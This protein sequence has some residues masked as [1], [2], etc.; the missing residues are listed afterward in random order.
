[1]GPGGDPEEA[2]DRDPRPGVPQVRRQPVG[3]LRGGERPRKPG[4]QRPDRPRRAARRVGERDAPQLRGVP[5]RLVRDPEGRG[6]DELHQHRLQGRLP[7]LDDQPRR[8]E[9]AGH[10]RPVPRPARPDQGRAAAARARGRDADRQ[11][12]GPRPVAV[13]VGAAGGADDRLRRRARRGRV[14]VDRRRPHHVHVGHDG[15]LEGRHQAERRRLLL[16]P[17]PARGGLRDRRQVGRRPGGATPSS[18]ACRCSTPTPRC[19]P[20]IRR[21]SPAAR[22]AYVERFSSAVLAAGRRRG[23]DG[24]QLDRRRQLLHLEHPHLRP[25]PAAQGAHLFAAPAPKDIYNEFQE[26]FGV[27]FIEGYGLTETGMAT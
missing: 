20:A 16:G 14:Q 26:R 22:V 6:G 25:R 9:E 3:E 18:A 23:G 2:G 13:E 1:M 11:P 27:K 7:L 17:R 21:S 12:G 24:L 8:G 4:R 15:P 19:C 5:A 10:H